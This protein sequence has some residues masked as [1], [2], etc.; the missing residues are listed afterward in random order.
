MCKVSTCTKDWRCI[1]DAWTQYHG[2]TRVNIYY[3]APMTK[4][5]SS[6]IRL[7][8]KFWCNTIQPIVPIFSVQSFFHFRMIV[9]SFHARAM[10][11]FYILNSQPPH[12][13]NTHKKYRDQ[14][15]LT[16]MAAMPMM[17]IW[18]ILIV[19]AVEPLMKCLLYQPNPIHSWGMCI[20]DIIY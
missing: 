8:E 2:M 15:H 11:L 13:L 14:I 19:T 10:E 12:R 3:P 16:D 6:Q 1:K 7:M 20:V 9:E 18:T 17:P 5:L 4:P